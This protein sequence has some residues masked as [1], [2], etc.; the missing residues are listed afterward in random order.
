M[1]TFITSLLAQNPVTKHTVPG[2]HCHSCSGVTKV[3]FVPCVVCKPIAKN[4]EPPGGLK[5]SAIGDAANESLCFLMQS[6]GW[7]FQL[8]TVL[9][10]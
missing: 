10:G 7:I 9:W 5:G 6:D 2:R 3:D 1:A 8:L 4:H